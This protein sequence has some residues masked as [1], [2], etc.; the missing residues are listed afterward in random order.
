MHHNVKNKSSMTTENKI[1]CVL[2]DFEINKITL[3][4]ATKQ[5]LLLLNVV[6]QSEQLHECSH[7]KG[8]ECIKPSSCSA[9]GCNKPM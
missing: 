7:R 9:F 2:M 1:K 8:K 6:G 5:I 4:E 3:R